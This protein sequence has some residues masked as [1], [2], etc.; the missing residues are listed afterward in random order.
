MKAKMERLKTF[1]LGIVL[2]LLMASCIKNNTQN[3]GSSDSFPN[4]IGNTRHYMVKDTTIQG[5]LDIGSTGLVPH[6]LRA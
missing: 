4:K 2:L 6:Q 3:T 1:Y 5:N